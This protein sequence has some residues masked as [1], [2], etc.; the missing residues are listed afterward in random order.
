MPKLCS[1][2]C[3]VGLISLSI[4]MCAADELK[5]GFELGIRLD[6]ARNYVSANGW[7]LRP[8]SEGLPNEWVVE[9]TS[10]GLFVCED[11]VVAVRRNF[12]G[13]LDDFASMVGSTTISLGPP[14]T[15]IVTFKSGSMRVS[16]IDARFDAED[17]S[18]VLIQLSSTDGKIG[19]LTNVWSAQGCAE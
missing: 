10:V 3:T 8:L 13:N 7:S 11:R 14:E 5:L 2:L 17:G 15:T 18:G 19:I 1:T 16:N 6:D 9:G 4:E 12:A